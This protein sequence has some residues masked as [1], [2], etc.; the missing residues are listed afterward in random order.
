MW[1]AKFLTPLFWVWTFARMYLGTPSQG[2]RCHCACLTSSF[3]RLLSV[4]IQ[5]TSTE[6]RG[7]TSYEWARLGK[8]GTSRL[9]GCGIHSHFGSC[10]FCQL[11]HRI[12]PSCTFCRRT[13]WRRLESPCTPPLSC[14]VST[15]RPGSVAILLLFRKGAPVLD[16]P[17]KIYFGFFSLRCF[18]LSHS[19]IF[20]FNCFI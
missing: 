9:W 18:Y 19:F 15:F 13:S 7:H 5:G 10:Q 12:F 2:A 11:S 16:R 8:H 20:N 4:H 6:E 17:R 1:R 3:R 14:L